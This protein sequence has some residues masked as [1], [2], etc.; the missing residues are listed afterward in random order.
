MLRA[1]EKDQLLVVRGSPGLGLTARG[2]VMQSPINQLVQFKSPNRYYNLHLVHIAGPMKG[3]HIKF[4]KAI[5]H[6][7]RREDTCWC[8][9]YRFPHRKGAGPCQN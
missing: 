7:A 5:A 6:K 4:Q 1:I 9:A 8:D 3:L 2:R